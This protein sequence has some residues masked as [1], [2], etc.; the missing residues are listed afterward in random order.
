MPDETGLIALGGQLS[1]ETV[2]E[3]YTKG[4]FPWSGFDPIPWFSPD[5]RLI[6]I[7]S[8]LKRS[9]SLRKV[10]RQNRFTIKFDFDF[11]AVIEA[12]AAKERPEQDGTW[13]N[14]RIP[15]VYGKLFDRG[16]AHCVGAYEND[17]LVGGLYGLSFGRAF[18]GESMFADVPNASKVAFSALCTF[19]IKHE[20]HFIDCQQETPH[21][22][23]LGASSVS[24][25]EFL[26]RLQQAFEHPSLHHSWASED[27]QHT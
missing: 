25:D 15:A 22:Q 11:R 6:L 9:K 2:A 12:C 19:L 27:L 23:S 18:F 14:G 26:T 24:R 13:I 8:E 16:I 3:A 20:F 4:I 7:P 17:T 10:I 1:P 21:L 5:P